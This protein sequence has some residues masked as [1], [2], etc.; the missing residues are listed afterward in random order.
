MQEADD[1][2]ANCSFCVLVLILSRSAVT[3]LIGVDLVINISDL[4]F[5]ERECGMEGFMASGEF[6]FLWFD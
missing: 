5:S 4:Q 6:L 3:G 2:D 1:F